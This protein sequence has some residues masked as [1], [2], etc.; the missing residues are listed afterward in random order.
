MYFP[1]LT[2]RDLKPIVY[3]DS[4]PNKRPRPLVIMVLDGYGIS[5]LKEGNAILAA[6]QPNMDNYMRAYPL[7]AVHAAGIEVGLPWG[8]MGN[9]ETGH[10]NIGSG[11]V[12][13]QSLPRITLAIQDKSFFENPALL[14]AAKHVKQNPE[15]A[16]H[17]IGLLS[18]GGVHSHIDHQLALLQFAEQQG[19][20]DRTYIHA[21]LDGRD[22]PPDSAGNFVNQLDQ[23]IKEHNAGHLVTLIGR[24][25]AMDRNNNWDRI[26]AAY[27]LLVHGKGT[28]YP[29]WQ[30]AVQAA[31]KNSDT[32]S[33]ETAPPMYVSHKDQPPRTIKDGDA[34]IFYNYRPD[35][36]KQLT[37]ALTKPDFKEFETI[38]FNNLKFVTMT[39]YDEALATL[40]AFPEEKIEHPLGRVLSENKLTQLRIAEGEKFTHVTQFFNGGE[41]GAYPG[42]ERI[43]INSIDTKDFSQHPHMSAE[44]ISDQVIKTIKE[45]TFDVIVINYANPDMVAHTGKLDATVAALEFLDE[46]IGRV[47]KATLTAKGAV[48]LTCDHG[49]AETIVSQLTHKRTTDHTN[50]PVPLIYIAP[51]NRVHP[52][53]TEDALMQVLANPIGVLADVAPTVLEILGLPVPKQMTA[54]SL[55]KS[56]G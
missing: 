25:Y 44:K 48:L 39:Q 31:F 37:A 20:G 18:S 6:K 10:Q 11:R 15:A 35:R 7:A 28:A 50:S 49:N 42:E 2:Y 36:A 46:Q 19:L 5:F 55:L 54:Q 45:S 51:D 43:R 1:C 41:E 26:K 40:I 3:H 27:D 8:E 9:S 14:E 23:A 4:M 38:R 13:Y 29:T 47:V 24:Y 12:I 22:S 16:L 34:V 56:L 32:K 53:K 17:T 30:E 52:P 21:F 33:F